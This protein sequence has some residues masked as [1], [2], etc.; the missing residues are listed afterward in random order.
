MEIS[1]QDSV[2]TV[3]SGPNRK[4]LELNSLHNTQPLIICTLLKAAIIK[5]H[6]G[7]RQHEGV[8]ADQKVAKDDPASSA[9]TEWLSNVLSAVPSV[10]WWW[11]RGAWWACPGGWAC[12]AD[13]TCGLSLR[14]SA[15]RRRSLVRHASTSRGR[16]FRSWSGS[17]ER[18]RE[19]GRIT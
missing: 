18:L 12:A 14:T 11:T 4:Q 15:L 7:T 16:V 6:Q 19:R 9:G 5:T 13:F 3:A 2:Q 10:R 17:G 1:D 8:K